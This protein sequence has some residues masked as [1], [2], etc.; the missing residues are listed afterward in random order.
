MNFLVKMMV[1]YSLVSCIHKC[2]TRVCRVRPCSLSL[3]LEMLAK[4]V[5]VLLLLPTLRQLGPKQAAARK[6]KAAAGV[7]EGHKF[8]MPLLPEKQKQNH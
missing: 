4:R 8:I 3:V 6:S 7:D 5:A 2:C 1:N